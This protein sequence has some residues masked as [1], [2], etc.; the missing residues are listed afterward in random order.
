MDFYNL[1]A[2]IALEG[3][4]QELRVRGLRKTRRAFFKWAR[5][6]RDA[7]IARCEL[8]LTHGT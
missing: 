1:M 3:L 8:V 4:Y 2:A 7:M 6:V 5:S